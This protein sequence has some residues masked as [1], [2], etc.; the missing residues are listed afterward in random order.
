MA[1]HA[2]SLAFV[3]SLWC[4]SSNHVPAMFQMNTGF[5]R[6]GYPCAGSWITYGLG[7]VTENLPGFVVLGTKTGTKGGPLNWSN[8][9]LP[10][11]CQGTVFRPGANPVLNLNRP[12]S[13]TQEDQRAQLD[14]L[15][16]VNK[17]HAQQ[18]PDNPAFTARMEN[19]ELAY[20]MQSAGGEL[21]NLSGESEATRALYGMDRKE[22][23]DFGGKCLMARRLVERGV[24]FVQVYCNEE[25]DA[26]AELESNHRSMAAQVDR[27]TAGL[28]ADLKQRG[29]L[30]ETL[31]IWGGEFG[32]MPVSEGKLGRDH[33]PHGFGLWLAG[34]GIRGGA[35]YGATDEIGYKASENPVSIPDLHATLLHQL[36]LDHE[37]LTYLHNSRHFR[38]TDV[39]GRVIR[40][41]LA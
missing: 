36:G 40:E 10:A 30:D 31:V 20:R 25:W 3:K 38:L 9:F 28:L 29:L 27:G 16:A 11:T 21:L 7:A 37:A 34:G 2:D 8:G 18:H 22:S 41:I 24:R 5:S 26:H 33:N 4:E 39:S 23:A 35:S 6:P 13:L 17:R 15:A 1:R 14:F 32:R 19:F 12:P